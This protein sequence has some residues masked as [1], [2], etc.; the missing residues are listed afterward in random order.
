MVDERGLCFGFGVSRIEREAQI[1]ERAR[2]YR[3]THDIREAGTLLHPF[4]QEY[5]A[6]V[7][8]DLQPSKMRNYSKR[9]SRV[10]KDFSP[11]LQKTRMS[12]TKRGCEQW[13]GPLRSG[14]RMQCSAEA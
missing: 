4:T 14:G 13:L 5:L 3:N 9:E 10:E 7:P 12:S 8:V 6:L 2:R 11:L 1:S